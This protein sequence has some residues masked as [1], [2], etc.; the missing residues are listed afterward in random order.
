[1]KDRKQSN[2]LRD[3][4]DDPV[5]TA[6]RFSQSTA[7]SHGRALNNAFKQPL[8]AM[9]IFGL[10]NVVLDARREIAMK[11][12]PR[13]AIVGSAKVD[14]IDGEIVVGPHE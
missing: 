10:E 8:D 9:Q 4:L 13:I 14:E 5:C 3:W 7:R 12:I 2:R 1:M 11:S 6:C